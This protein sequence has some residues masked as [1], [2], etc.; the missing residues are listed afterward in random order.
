MGILVNW[1]PIL[2][3]AMWDAAQAIINVQAV[4]SIHA[5]GVTIT[6]RAIMVVV[7]VYRAMSVLAK[8]VCVVGLCIE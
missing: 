1:S 3:L 6:V 8:A 4:H 7:V 5:P 2:D